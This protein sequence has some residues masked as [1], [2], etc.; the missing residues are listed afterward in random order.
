MVMD[1]LTAIEASALGV[2]VRESVS[3]FAYPGIIAA[4]TIGLAFLVGANAAVDLRILGYASSLPLAPMEKFFPVMYAGFWVNALSGI[5][6]TVAYAT[7]LLTNPVFLV[8]V[9][10]IVL[11][12]INLRLIRVR[13]FAG[14]G[15][16][17][18]GPL[19][20]SARVLA[21]TSLA[22]WTLAIVFG[23]LTAYTQL[24]ATTFGGGG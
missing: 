21:S 11:A 14:P 18:E 10:L 20:R 8:K 2:W 3:L 22:L 4:H 23:R 15:P 7:S 12:V 24:I 19:P 13:V 16:P 5:A 6:L 17:A 9:T 1:V